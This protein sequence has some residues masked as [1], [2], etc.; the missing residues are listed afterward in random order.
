MGIDIIA[1]IPEIIVVGFGLL[2]LMLSVF[3][4]K[5]FDKAV[6]PLSAAGLVTALGAIFIFNF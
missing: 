5:K 1:I 6:A 3:T 4:G 2:V